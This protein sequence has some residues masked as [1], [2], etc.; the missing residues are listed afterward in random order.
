MLTK[1]FV[2]VALV[3]MAGAAP[4]DVYGHQ[5]DY[6]SQP[7]PYQF[8]YGVHDDYSGND[9]GQTET[10]DGHTVKGSYS[11]KLPDGRKQIVNY[12]ADHIGGYRA[13]VTY[14]GKAHHPSHAVHAAPSY[15]S[16]PAY[17][18]EPTYHSAPSYH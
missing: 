7:I 6:K 13:E 11:V 2:A 18:S 1:V 14:Q 17:H 16:E 8:G 10:S 4:T 5:E 3:A 15:H 9:F 12:I